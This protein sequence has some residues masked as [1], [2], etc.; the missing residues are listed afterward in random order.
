MKC[1][2]SIVYRKY[3]WQTNANFVAYRLFCKLC[4][5]HIGWASGRDA[6]VIKRNFKE[7]N[8]FLKNLR[9]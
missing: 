7:E 4:R 8:C 6:A 1:N 3:T 5:K 2:C 9:L